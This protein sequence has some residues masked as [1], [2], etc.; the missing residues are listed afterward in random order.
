[1]EQTHIPDHIRIPLLEALEE[2]RESGF[3]ASG[4]LKKCSD[5]GLEVD[6]C[7][8]IQLPLKDVD[9]QRIIAAS[10]KASFG[11]GLEKIDNTTVRPTWELKQDQFTLAREVAFQNYVLT[12]A[13][14]ACVKL[15]IFE[16]ASNIGVEL[17][18]LVLYDEGALFKPQTE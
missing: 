17:D 6:L 8:P 16:D 14:S 9:A 12:L 2:I 1:M 5:P 3:A 13:R 4:R 10:K 11:D 18:K 7:G 15:G